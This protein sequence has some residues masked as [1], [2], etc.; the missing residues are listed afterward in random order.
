MAKMTLD[1][2]V[3]QLRAAYGSALRAMVLY[4][5]A[6]GGEHH[7]EHSDY[8]VLVIVRDLSIESMRAAS[9]AG[10]AWV[11]AK[12]PPPLTLTE[13]EWRSSVDVFAIEHADIRDRH[14]MLYADAGY[15]P[16]Q[17]ITIA[18]HDLRFQLEYEAMG[19][20]LRLRRHIL[21]SSDDA[22]DR[23]KL[24][25]ASASQVLV[26]FRT[27]LRHAGETPPEDNEA[28][29]RAA[30]KRAGFDPAP[31]VEV[32]GHR[33]GAAK[34][35]GTRVNDVLAGYHTGLQRVVAYVDALPD[36]G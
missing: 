22:A 7:A 8:N 15:D 31:F 32:V 33:R 20:L 13:A 6:A 23:A 28:L 36:A 10:R 18:P 11:E 5:S 9:A 12:N 14:K 30:G 26:L 3:A 29:C 2:L 19:T 34:L 24:L 17:G 27:L 16:L 4:G 25:A 35:T 1:D 21:G